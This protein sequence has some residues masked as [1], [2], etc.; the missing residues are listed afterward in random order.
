MPCAVVLNRWAAAGSFDTGFYIVQ[1]IELIAG[2]SNLVRM[3]LNARDGM[4]M[5]GKLRA[6]PVARGGARGIPGAGVSPSS[7]SWG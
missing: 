2:A 4:R 3:G 5:A 7:S 1:A 6:A